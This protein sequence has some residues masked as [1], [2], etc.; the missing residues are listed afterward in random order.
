MKTSD[1]NDVRVR[2]L[3]TRGMTL[4]AF[5][6]ALR[7]DAGFASEDP[8]HSRGYVRLE[9]DNDSG[10]GGG[11]AARIWRSVQLPSREPKDVLEMHTKGDCETAAL[12]RALIYAG[13]RLASGLRHH[14][15]F[16]GADSP[17]GAGIL[18]YIPSGSMWG[19]K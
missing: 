9:M 13:V 10:V 15:I 1:L 18:H 2:S 3:E 14:D 5:Y 17:T 6:G 11:I 19:A 4:Q 16:D 12:A 7:V 8:D